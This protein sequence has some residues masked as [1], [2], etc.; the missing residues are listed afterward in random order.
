MFDP[1]KPARAS[2]VRALDGNALVEALV[3][4]PLGDSSRVF[5]RVV[6]AQTDGWPQRAETAALVTV[7]AVRTRLLAELEGDR[8]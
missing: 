5:V 2:V 6:V 3:A 1:F 4:V 7:E 8:E